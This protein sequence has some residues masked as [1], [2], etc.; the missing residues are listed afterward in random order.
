MYTKLGKNLAW[1]NSLKKG[2]VK[3]NSLEGNF[4]YVSSLLQAI[5][6]KI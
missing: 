6:A 4:N 2:L 5:S 1:Q 3:Y